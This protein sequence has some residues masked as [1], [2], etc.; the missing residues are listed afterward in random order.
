MATYNDL[1]DMFDA[2][3][4]QA[5]YTAAEV[6]EAKSWVRNI[7]N[8]SLECVIENRGTVAPLFDCSECARVLVAHM[9]AAALDGE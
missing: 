4:E 8:R 5:G 2:Q 6:A 1:V 7:R 9:C 3:L